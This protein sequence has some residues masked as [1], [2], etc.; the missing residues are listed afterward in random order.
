MPRFLPPRLLGLRLAGLAAL[1]AAA[2][3]LSL[4]TGPSGIDAHGSLN[5]LFGDPDSMARVVLLD[6]RL[7]RVLAAFGVGAVLALSG[8]L[9]QTLFRNPLADPYV[10]GVS[11]GASVGALLAMLTGAGF[12]ATQSGALLGAFAAMLLVQALGRGGSTRL[13]LTGVI[14]ASACGALVSVL[15]AV[16][17]AGQLRGMVFW[18]AGDLGWAQSPWLG[19]GVALAAVTAS[20][21]L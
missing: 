17:D 2:L 16:A 19:I 13:L 20:V 1:A 15:L 3:V 8:V 12:L 11:G 7:P 21:L 14:T 4:I 10:L 18:L 9:L 6:L 5:A